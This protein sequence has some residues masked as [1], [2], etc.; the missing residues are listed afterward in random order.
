[1]KTHVRRMNHVLEGNP[2]PQGKGQILRGWGVTSGSSRRESARR[3]GCGLLLDYFGRPL[4]GQTSKTRKFV[5]SMS[6]RSA[7]VASSLRRTVAKAH[8]PDIFDDQFTSS[9]VS[10]IG[11]VICPTPGK[12]KRRPAPNAIHRDPP[13][14][15]V[16]HCTVHSQT[17]QSVGLYSERTSTRRQSEATLGSGLEPGASSAE[18]NTAL[19]TLA[20]GVRAAA[21]GGLAVP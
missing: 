14:R 1:M 10:L 2:D 19:P 20:H 18:H 21:L 4:F 16:L 15:R 3:R 7:P 9:S 6:G 11:S 17:L 8:S 13:V 12:E 5:P